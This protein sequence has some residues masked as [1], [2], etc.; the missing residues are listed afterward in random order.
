MVFRFSGTVTLC[1]SHKKLSDSNVQ[2]PTLKARP[3]HHAIGSGHYID[4]I[5]LRGVSKQGNTL[6]NPKTQKSDQQRDCEWTGF[7]IDGRVVVFG[8]SCGV[9]GVRRSAALI[10]RLRIFRDER[11]LVK[12]L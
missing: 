9:A 12:R 11:R 7:A 4:I 1:S 6:P 10:Y 5:R 2:S 8:V 3:N